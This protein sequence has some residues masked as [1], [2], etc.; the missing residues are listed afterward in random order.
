[1]NTSTLPLPAK[2]SP[3]TSPDQPS[4]SSFPER[5]SN[6]GLSGLRFL[7]DRI[8]APTLGAMYGVVRGLGLTAIT[9]LAITDGLATWLIAL[10]TNAR[11]PRARARW[12]HRW[13]QAA[14]FVLGL[15]TTMRGHAPVS[16]VVVA[17]HTS[18]LD[19]LVL[20][21]LH[22]CVFVAGGELRRRPLLGLL[23]RLGGT[24]FVESTRGM[25]LQLAT[26]AIERALLR[27]QVVV[28]FPECNPLRGFTTALFQPAA[29]L[30]CTLTATAIGYTA[31]RNGEL[32]TPVLQRENGLSA[33]LAQ[34]ITRRR[35]PVAV[36]F[37]NPRFH[38]G[39]RKHLAR[40]LRSELVALDAASLP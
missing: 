40:Q 36:A 4:A 32:G 8:L 20:A 16:G 23:A 19:A 26:F 6:V 15:R 12:L 34:I 33:H 17:N 7:T 22:P 18:L 10:P 31:S 39:D 21:A 3:A 38:Q 37:D 2:L 13:S 1:M 11:L 9:A 30:G 24:I 5:V 14:R 28:I 35:N 25:D 29:E 27:R